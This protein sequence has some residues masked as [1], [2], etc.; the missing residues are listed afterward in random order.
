M[1]TRAMTPA[2][3]RAAGMAALVRELGPAG[4]LRFLREFDAG[5]G[6]YTADREQ[7]LPTGNVE[8]LAEA[9]QKKRG[10]GART[11]VSE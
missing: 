3:L 1:S 10:K 8:E 9:I 11:S 2:E 7:W 4:A 6:D 5:A